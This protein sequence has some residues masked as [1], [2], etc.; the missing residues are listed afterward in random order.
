[1]SRFGDSFGRVRQ[2]RISFARFRARDGSDI[3]LVVAAAVSSNT[4][5]I[6]QERRE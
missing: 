4:R 2:K 1:M 3:C 6:N 5:V